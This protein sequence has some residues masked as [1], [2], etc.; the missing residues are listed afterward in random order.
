M[1]VDFFAEILASSLMNVLPSLIKLHISPKLVTITFVNF[2]VYGHT[3]IRQL[4]VPLL[5][6]S[7]TRNLIAV[8]LMQ[9]RCTSACVT[10]KHIRV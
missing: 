1:S 7:F 6:P 8:I 9:C 3:L 10:D 4:L 5:P 2:A